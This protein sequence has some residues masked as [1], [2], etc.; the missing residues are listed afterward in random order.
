MHAN[1]EFEKKYLTVLM[2]MLHLQHFLTIYIKINGQQ[3]QDPRA[4]IGRVYHIDN[5]LI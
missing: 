4:Y 5:T 1:K 3:V 2:E